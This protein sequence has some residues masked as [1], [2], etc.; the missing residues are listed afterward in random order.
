MAFLVAMVDGLAGVS[1]ASSGSG[2]QELPC[3]EATAAV[4]F[5]IF[6]DSESKAVAESNSEKDEFESPD[7]NLFAVGG[8]HGD[9]VGIAGADAAA[10]RVAA[11]TSSPFLETLRRSWTT[12][13]IRS[14]SIADS[15]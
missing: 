13:W 5:D 8:E 6:L 7:G 9:D 2:G 11:V 15:F 1:P 4:H 14:T 12:W 10:G 3:G